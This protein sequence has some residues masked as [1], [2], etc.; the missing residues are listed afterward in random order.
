MASVHDDNEEH[1]VGDGDGG[2]W[3][4]GGDY[5]DLMS[6]DVHVGVARMA[7]VDAGVALVEHD[8]PTSP[9]LVDSHDSCPFPSHSQFLSRYA[10]TPISPGLLLFHRHLYPWPYCA[11]HYNCHT[12]GLGPS[13]WVR[14]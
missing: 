7:H 12:I 9:S 1:D 4:N 13:T 8:S 3:Q 6:W 5:V 2:P 14:P 10:S 11:P